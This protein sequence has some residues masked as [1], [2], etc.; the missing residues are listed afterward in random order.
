[1]MT[2]SYA[3][4]VANELIF[5]PLGG[6]G[7]IGMNL[8]LYGYDGRWLMVDLGVSFGDDRTPG[9]DIMVPDPT[10]IADRHKALDGL[11]ITHGHEDHLGAVAYLWKKLQCPVY[12]SPFACALLRRKFEEAD[13]ADK[14]PLHEV[15]VGGRVDVGAFN[16]EFVRAAHSIPEAQILAIR[17][18][19][20]TIVHA[21]DWKLDPEPLVG[22]PTDEVALKKLGDEGVLALVCDST[23]VFVSGQT[24]SEA[25]LRK[26]LTEIIGR[27][28][29]RVALAGFASNA[30]R[31]E[32]VAVAAEAVGRHPA[33]IGRSM[34]RIYD[35]ARECG[36]LK[37]IEFLD[38]VEASYL[39]P[40]KVVLYVTGSQGEP[41]AALSRIAANDHPNIVLE[42]GDVAIFSSRMIPGNELAIGRLQ[43]QLARLG[44]EVITE[45][46][47]FVHVS[48]HPARSELTSLYQWIR[49]QLLVPIHGEARHLFEQAALAEECQIPNTVV[50]ENGAMVRIG[51]GT[52]DIVDDVTAGRWAI[53]G[54]R[55]IPV[56]G[57]VLRMRQRMKFGGT[58]VATVALDKKGRLIGD[59]Q[60][61]VHGLIDG[62]GEDRIRS[63]IVDAIADAIE[64]L[65]LSARKTDSE[66]AEAARIAVRRTLRDVV[67]K[68]PVTDIHVVRM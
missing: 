16:V 62:D 43:N 13:I 28:E 30:A 33:L 9:V 65:P 40:E 67:G 11:V 48:G 23:N 17:N 27:C 20:G 44:V 45:D 25:E 56:D 60:L 51:P 59:P 21:T 6:A 64:D 35:A 10:F 34:H 5:L 41:R 2:P 58:A 50:A 24:G 52:P 54:K 22:M 46:D 7:E 42:E 15:P 19:V 4:D 63:T 61:T 37:G 31:M 3:E 66:V 55:M 26:S 49:P 12:A 57:A 53:D 39:P 29:G 47:D 1:M 8:N 36:Y 14:V 32:S 38:E 18:P 68:R